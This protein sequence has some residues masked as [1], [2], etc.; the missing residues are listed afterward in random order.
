MDRIYNSTMEQIHEI[1]RVGVN[2][3][4]VEYLG[5]LVDI[6]KDINK[7]CLM[8]EERGHKPYHKETSAV[9]HYDEG[10]H[11]KHLFDRMVAAYGIYEHGK[12][13]LHAGE[14]SKHMLDGL[15]KMMDALCDFVEAGM[16][17]VEIPEE[18][19]IMMKH[20]HKLLEHK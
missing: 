17:A 5:E 12:K 9:F 15:E 3:R 11:M 20:I 10:S 13:K 1:E 16:E 2:P 4:N 8:E 7:I 6:I 14:G 19:E 18:K